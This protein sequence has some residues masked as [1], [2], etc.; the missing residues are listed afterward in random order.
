M[1]TATINMH[2]TRKVIGDIE[3]PTDLKGNRPDEVLLGE[4]RQLLGYKTNVTL[5]AWWK[6]FPSGKWWRYAIMAS[7]AWARKPNYVYFL[8]CLMDAGKGTHRFDDCYRHLRSF[9]GKL[10]EKV[11]RSKS[12]P[13][14]IKPHEGNCSCEACMAVVMENVRRYIP[15]FGKERVAAGDETMATAAS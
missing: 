4:A 13:P 7:Q 6:V 8:K 14:K 2:W 5:H 9:Y 12:E 3:A 15:G 11:G 1:T 10:M